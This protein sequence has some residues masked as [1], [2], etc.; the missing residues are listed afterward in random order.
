MYSKV[1]LT[2]PLTVALLLCDLFRKSSFK[3][4]PL[5]FQRLNG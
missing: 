4:P 1:V 3:L 5:F 2:A